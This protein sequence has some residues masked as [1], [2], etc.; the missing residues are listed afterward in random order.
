MM[1]IAERVEEE[2]KAK[3]KRIEK[4]IFQKQAL[5]L[6]VFGSEEGKEALAYLKQEFDKPGLMDAN[7]HIIAYNVAA[8]DVVRYIEEIMRYEEKDL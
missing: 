7:P 3:I 8:R 5:F 1:S 2:R 6:R 4:I